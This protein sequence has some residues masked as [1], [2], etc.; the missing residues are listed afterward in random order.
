MAS[1]TH[2]KG[3]GY[4]LWL[5]GFLGAHRFYFGYKWTGLLWLLTGG[6]F[7]VGWIVDLFLIPG[8]DNKA[9]AKYTEGKVDYTMAWLLHTFVGP[10]GIAHFYMGNTTTGIIWLLTAGGFGVGWIY[11]FWRLNDLVDEANRKG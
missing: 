8:M 3:I 11:D 10:L 2:S 7:G 9:D 4:I 1:N 5:F 6:L